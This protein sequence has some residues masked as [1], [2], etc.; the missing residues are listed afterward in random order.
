MKLCEVQGRCGRFG[1]KKISF[2]CRY[3]NPI[4]GGRSAY[5]LL[6]MATELTRLLQSAV[7]VYFNKNWKTQF[8]RQDT[9]WIRQRQY[10][11]KLLWREHGS[12][13]TALRLFLEMLQL[14]MSP[15]VRNS[16]KCRYFLE[17]TIV[18]LSPRYVQALTCVVVCRAEHSDT[19]NKLT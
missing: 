11:G 2:P 12:V 3:S 4:F 17:S 6:I 5:N 15:F 1:E 13:Q 18:A 16:G 10:V 9:G 14:F 19:N 7:E 8:N